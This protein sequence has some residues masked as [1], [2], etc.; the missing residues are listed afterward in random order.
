MLILAM[1]TCKDLMDII[2]IISPETIDSFVI[3]DLVTSVVNKI[4]AIDFL[5][6]ASGTYTAIGWL[7]RIRR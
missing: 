3:I 7:K 5:L 2:N 6:R 4:S 1:F